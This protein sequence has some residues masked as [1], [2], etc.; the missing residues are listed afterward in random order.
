M[1]TK[2]ILKQTTLFLLL[3]LMCATLLTAIKLNAQVAA[4]LSQQSQIN[5]NQIANK[6]ANTKLTYKIIDAPNQTFG[7]DISADDR[8]LIHQPSI[9]AVAGNE[10]FK[11]KGDA[12]TVARLVIS[13]LKKGEWPPAITT[14]EL[15]KL[16]VIQ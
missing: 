3:C 5:N 10:G 15:K 2:I 4:P 11:T 16:K 12:A 14:E 7:Y 13:K 8:K 1:K 6:F 9:P